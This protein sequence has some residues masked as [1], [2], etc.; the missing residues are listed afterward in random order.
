MENKSVSSNFIALDIKRFKWN[1]EDKFLFAALS[2]MPEL[3][4]L[5]DS[6]PNM[7]P[8]VQT[9]NDLFIVGRTGAYKFKFSIT[10]P[11]DPTKH[12]KGCYVIFRPY[13]K[14]PTVDYVIIHR[15]MKKNKESKG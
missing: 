4:E 13:S 15:D 3:Q 7:Y 12:P 5:L 11:T 1:K 10:R 2:D 9:E 6:K 14:I 8:L